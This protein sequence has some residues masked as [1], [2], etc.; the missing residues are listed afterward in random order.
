MRHAEDDVV[1]GVVCV[2]DVVSTSVCPQDDVACGVVDVLCV[3]W[4]V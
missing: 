3:L 1:C 4:N 2:D